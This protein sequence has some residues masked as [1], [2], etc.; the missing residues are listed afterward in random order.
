MG[1]HT[2]FHKKNAKETMRS[3]IF[4]SPPKPMKGVNMQ[5]L[6][7]MGLQLAREFV[8]SQQ[9]LFVMTAD[10]GGE[11]VTVTIRFSPPA[12]KMTNEQV[13]EYVL[14]ANNANNTNQNLS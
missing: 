3:F 2:I 11:Q 6:R 7:E 1:R 5:H 13:W 4:P 12:K 14:N 9:D 10:V 8:A